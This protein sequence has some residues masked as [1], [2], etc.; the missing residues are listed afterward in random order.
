VEHN[1]YLYGIMSGGGACGVAIVIIYWLRYRKKDRADVDK[2]QA[3][4]IKTLA[5]AYQIKV[6]AEIAISQEWKRITDDLKGQLHDER[7]ECDRQLQL[8]Q[9][10]INQQ[11]NH[12]ND[13]KLEIS[14]LKNKQL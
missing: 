10:Q 9:N 6:G 11:N 5:E 2:T 14:T 8:M 4:S 1:N 3:S 13:M 12:I 7:V